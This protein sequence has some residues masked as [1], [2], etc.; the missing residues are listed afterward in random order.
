MGAHFIKGTFSVVILNSLH[1]L[2]STDI[3]TSGYR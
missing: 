1:L 3:L 2:H